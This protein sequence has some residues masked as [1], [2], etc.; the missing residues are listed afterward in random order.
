MF[1]FK[2]EP[3]SG[4]YNK[5]LAKITSLVQL[6]VSVRTVEHTH[7]TSQYTAITLTTPVPTRSAVVL[8]KHFL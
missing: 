1:R 6:C 7:I 3:S 8:A 4:S 5:C 2:Q